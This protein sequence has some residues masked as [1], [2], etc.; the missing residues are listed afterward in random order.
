[1]T[2]AEREEKRRLARIKKLTYFSEARKHFFDRLHAHTGKQSILCSEASGW[3]TIRQCVMWTYGECLVTHMPDD[4]K[5][6]VNKFAIQLI[7]QM[8]DKLAEQEVEQ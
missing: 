2:V 3:D 4:K 7:D 1:M 5:E 6:E 8:Y